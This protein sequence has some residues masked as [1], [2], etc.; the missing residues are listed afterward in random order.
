MKSSRFITETFPLAFL[1][2]DFD[3]KTLRDD[4]KKR[5]FFYNQLDTDRFPIFEY[6]TNRKNYESLKEAFEEEFFVQRG[7]SRTKNNLHIPSTNTLA[8]LFT[9]NNYTPSQKI[10]NTCRSF[11]KESGNKTNFVLEDERVNSLPKSTPT[12]S[13][14]TLSRI[15]LFLGITLL[16][17]FVF[18]QLF[19][20]KHERLYI[21][22]PS[23]N[24]I[25]PRIVSIEGTAEKASE[26]WV[27]VKSKSTNKYYVQQP[28][29]IQNGKDWVGR[30]II[31]SVSSEDVGQ[32]FEIKAFLNPAKKLK[33][34]DELPAWP[35]SEVSTEGIEV[36]R[37]S[38]L[39]EE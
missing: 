38:K 2:K 18:Y 7:I 11:A 5:Y 35:A 31:G 23:T 25:V 14:F 19:I 6:N 13:M 28:I 9:D 16:L 15:L 22:S 3:F 32:A 26:V 21:K 33:K 1:N 29:E 36:I 39:T 10:L 30:V 27:V 4:I 17:S 37:G 12:K 8:L 24:T 34:G 20:H